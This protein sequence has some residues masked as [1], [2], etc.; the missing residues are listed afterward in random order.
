MP[1]AIRIKFALIIFV[2]NRFSEEYFMRPST[3]KLSPNHTYE[4][5]YGLEIDNGTSDFYIPI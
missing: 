3:A 5:Y 2:L 4:Y 1:A